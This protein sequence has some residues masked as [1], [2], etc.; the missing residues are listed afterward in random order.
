MIP[1]APYKSGCGKVKQGLD[2]GL[3]QLDS[4]TSGVRSNAHS[5]DMPEWGIKDSSIP[6][7]EQIAIDLSGSFRS[8]E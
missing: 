1:A 5:Q 2:S 6:E 4:K 3:F 7:R 8:N